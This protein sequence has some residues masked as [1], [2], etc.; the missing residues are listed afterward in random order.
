MFQHYISYIAA[1]TLPIQA[2]GGGGGFIQP[3][4]HTFFFPSNWMLSPLIIVKETVSSKSAMNFLASTVLSFL[5]KFD[6]RGI[7]HTV[8]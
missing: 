2:G 4:F 3:V 7:E 8:L 6:E 5:R 1:Y